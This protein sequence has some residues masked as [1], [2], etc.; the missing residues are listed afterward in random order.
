MDN[1][2]APIYNKDGKEIEVSS[3]TMNTVFREHCAFKDAPCNYYGR[4]WYDRCAWCKDNN[5]FKRKTED[6]KKPF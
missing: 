4:G 1:L 3:V 5:G 6:N 2:A